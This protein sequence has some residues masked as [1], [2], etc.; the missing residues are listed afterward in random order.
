V[1]TSLPRRFLQTALFALGALVV[2]EGRYIL[3]YGHGWA[4]I[5][6]K[7]GHEYL[8]LAIPL[9]L[10]MVAV[11]LVLFVVELRRRPAATSAAPPSR[12]ASFWRAWLLAYVVLCVVFTGQELTEGLLSSGHAHGLAGVVDGGGWIAFVLGIGVAALVALAMRGAEVA[13]ARGTRV[14]RLPARRPPLWLP[15][16]LVLPRARPVGRNLAP[17]GPPAGLL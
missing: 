1:S 7:A 10:A 17:R 6:N 11:G 15:I 14:E 16:S 8:A 2:H 5:V 13:L 12:P 4:E 9:V 3:G